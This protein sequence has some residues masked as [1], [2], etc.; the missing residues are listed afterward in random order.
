M[1]STHVLTVLGLGILLSACATQP[2]V[3]VG[4]KPGQF[5]TYQCD[6]GKRLQAR[7]AADGSSV[8]VRFEGGY[9]LDRKGDGMFEGEGFTLTSANGMLALMHNGK[10]AAGNCKPA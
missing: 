10:P 1:K 4:M 2:S 6:G 5:V 9:E 3:P 8:R 7:L